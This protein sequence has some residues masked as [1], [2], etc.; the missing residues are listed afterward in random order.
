MTSYKRQSSDRERKRLAI[1]LRSPC[2][3]VPEVLD[4]EIIAN[5]IEFKSRHY[6]LFETNA[7]GEGMNTLFPES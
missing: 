6:I 3:V 2:W 1:Y 7:I 5:E 4:Y